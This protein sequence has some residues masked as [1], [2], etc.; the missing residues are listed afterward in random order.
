MFRVYSHKVMKRRRLLQGL[1]ALAATFTT[2]CTSVTEEPGPFNFG[3]VNRREQAYNVEY[4][5]R[6]GGGDGEVIIDGSADIA[7]RPPDPSERTVLAFEDLVRVTDGDEIHARVQVD[8]RTF[9]ETYT[10]TCN[11]SENAENN[12]F[13]QIR[14]PEAPADT[15]L[16]MEFNGSECGG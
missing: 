1:T 3:I 11:Q 5:L 14:H 2:G 16:G 13:F 4:T 12:W 7:A 9:E 8:G 15:E 10:V 6:D